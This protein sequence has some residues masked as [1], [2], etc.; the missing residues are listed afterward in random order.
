[1]DK[2][3]EDGRHYDQLFSGSSPDLPY[4]QWAIAEFGDPVLELAAGTGRLTIPLAA[5]GIDITGLERAPSMLA[6]ARVKAA[7][8]GISIPF[9][10]GDMRDFSLDRRFALIFIA[11]NTINH[12]LTDEDLGHCLAAVRHHLLP[13]GVF[14]LDTFVPDPNLLINDDKRYPFSE[15]EDPDGRGPVIVTH[16]SYYDA[17]TQIKHNTTYHRYPDQE[18]EVVGSL[19]MRMYFPAE[20]DALLVENGFR[21][22]HKFADYDRA[23]FHDQAKTQLSVCCLA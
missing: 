9:H 12:L 7:L 10:P 1:M 18:E 14:L 21:L 19:D 20:L 8:A 17:A 22:R 11:N 16:T 23:P 6:Q 3:Y 13:D 5:A 15:Y 4:Y 2:I